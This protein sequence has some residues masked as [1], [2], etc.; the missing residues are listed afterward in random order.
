MNGNHQ[1]PVGMIL[2][3]SGGDYRP[4]DNDYENS[5]GSFHRWDLMGRNSG[6]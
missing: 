5:G 3:G 1:V 4:F 2:T 6:Y